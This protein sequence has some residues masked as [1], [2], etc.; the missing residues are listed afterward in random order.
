MKQVLR[1]HVF[2]SVGGH[3][4][5]QTWMVALL[6]S[7]HRLHRLVEENKKSFQALT[8]SHNFVDPEVSS[9][10]PSSMKEDG[11]LSWFFRSLLVDSARQYA[12]SARARAIA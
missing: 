12:V 1:L 8:E 5:R 6:K 9:S 4:H 3:R 11:L 2:L 7:L 10:V